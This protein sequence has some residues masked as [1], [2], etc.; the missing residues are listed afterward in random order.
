LRG[1]E[2]ETTGTRADTKACQTES[3]FQY[4]MAAVKLKSGKIDEA[5]ERQNTAAHWSAQ[6]PLPL[7]ASGQ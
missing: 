1:Y 4:A 6:P 5:I 7:E 3:E 2:H